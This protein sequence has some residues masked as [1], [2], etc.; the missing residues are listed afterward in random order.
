M[1]QTAVY[2]G[3]LMVI[4][5]LVCCAQERTEESPLLC[6]INNYELSL[7]EFEQHL[8]AE[9]ELD[10]DFKVTRQAKE[11]FLEELIRKELLIQEAKKLEL[12]NREKFIRTIERYWEMTLIRDLITLKSREI[13]A[14]IQIDGDEIAAR[15]QEMKAD[16]PDLPELEKVRDTIQKELRGKEKSR[17]LAEWMSELR[18]NG[19][20]EIDDTLFGD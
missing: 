11:A 5:G 4:L 15:Y 8:M 7:A 19:R 12:D 2:L 17:L 14:T 3:A 20:V 10:P 9:Q 16:H 13:E 6:R 1:N 18:E